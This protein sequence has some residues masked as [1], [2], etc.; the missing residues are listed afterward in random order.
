M[1]MNIRLEAWNGSAW[2]PSPVGN[3]RACILMPV[4]A[5][6]GETMIW[7]VALDVP[8]AQCRLLCRA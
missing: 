2:T 8:A 3:D 7:L 1:V 6:P 5:A 4:S